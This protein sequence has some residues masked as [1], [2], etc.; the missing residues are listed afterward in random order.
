MSPGRVENSLGK[1][2]TEINGSNIHLDRY[3]GKPVVVTEAFWDREGV[4]LFKPDGRVHI[5]PGSTVA[6]DSGLIVHPLPESISGFKKRA[7]VSAD[8][9]A[10]LTDSVR[11]NFLKNP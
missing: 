3:C 7:R 4:Y 6:L 2:V 5:F 9:G 11:Q 10:I 1:S 8:I